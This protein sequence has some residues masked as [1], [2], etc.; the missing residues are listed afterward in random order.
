MLSITVP[1]AFSEKKSCEIWETSLP[2]GYKQ[3][4]PACFICLAGWSWCLQVRRFHLKIQTS[5]FSNIRHWVN[6]H[7]AALDRNW[8]VSWQGMSSLLHWSPHTSCGLRHLCTALMYVITSR[9]SWSLGY[10]S[11]C[12]L[13]T[14]QTK[15]A[16]LPWLMWLLP[17]GCC[18]LFSPEKF[19]LIPWALA[20]WAS[21][22]P[23]SI[24]MSYL[25]VPSPG[26]RHPE[27]QEGVFD[28]CVPSA[29][30]DAWPRVYLT[31]IHTYSLF[32]LPPFSPFFLQ[33]K[34]W[35]SERTC[36]LSQSTQHRPA[37]PENKGMEIHDQ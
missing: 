6:S 15:H 24:T 12:L 29:Q 3:S 20:W 1:C 26:D 9:A 18:P 14:H 35:G 11:P 31:L 27:A 33:A 32:C 4:H 10:R 28:L 2:R 7:K 13:G 30:H 5:V 37:V 23:S 17:Q 25:L 16:S 22:C 36:N 19:L 21:D 8:G 34:K